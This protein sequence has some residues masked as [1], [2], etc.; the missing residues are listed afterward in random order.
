M[1]VTKCLLCV[2]DFYFICVII[3]EIVGVPGVYF[4]E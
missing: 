1:V 3:I 2:I 4:Y